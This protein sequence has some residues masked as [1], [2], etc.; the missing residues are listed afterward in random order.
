MSETSTTTD[1]STTTLD[2][3]SGGTGHVIYQSDSREPSGLAFASKNDVGYI[4]MVSDDG[5]ILALESGSS[6]WESD[7]YGNDDD[8]DFECI[9]RAKGKLMIGVE[10]GA[11]VGGGN[12]SSPVIRRYDQT[13]SNDGK[14]L[15]NFTNS[16][17]TL[18]GMTIDG[19]GGMEGMTFIP[20]EDCPSSWGTASYYGGFFL[21]AVQ[22][23]RGTIYVYD[24]PQGGGTSHTVNA[25][26]ASFTDE[27]LGLKISDMC[28][29]KNSQ[30]LIVLYDDTARG[31]YTGVGS[32][33]YV[34]AIQVLK[35]D[36]G[37]FISTLAERTPYV[38]SEGVAYNNN[39]LFIALDQSGS[40]DSSTSQWGVNGLTD[41]TVTKYSNF[42]LP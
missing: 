18:N 42:D 2:A 16:E 5:Y 28:Y 37:T 38:G 39:N 26:V 15:G 35:L 24:L 27:L 33:D 30:R 17:W 6:T 14:E 36:N 25:P 12:Y 41:N 3:W 22:S 10:G 29:D 7:Q 23:A 9:T 13:T 4:Y 1:S 34:G 40:K 21:V 20:Q 8:H 31:D 11:D 19:A 32:S